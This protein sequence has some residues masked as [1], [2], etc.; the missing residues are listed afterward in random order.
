MTVEDYFQVKIDS[1]EKIL[2]WKKG[3]LEN[4]SEK[5]KLLE[6][7]VL[8]L[9]GALNQ[10]QDVKNGWKKECEKEQNEKGGL[11]LCVEP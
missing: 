3:E 11:K 1:I 7:E 5:V 9:T 8:A 6:R 10:L 2:L 4:L